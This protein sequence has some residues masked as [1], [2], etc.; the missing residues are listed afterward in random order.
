MLYSNHGDAREQKSTT[1]QVALKATRSCGATCLISTKNAGQHWQPLRTTASLGNGRKEPRAS[2][3][4]V[5]SCQM[6]RWLVPSEVHPRTLGCRRGACAAPVPAQG[7]CS[8]A[9]LTM[10]SSPAPLR[11]RKPTTD[12]RNTPA[13][14]CSSLH[15]HGM[16]MRT[17]G[18]CPASSPVE[19][20]SRT[21]CS[22]KTRAPKAASH[23]GSCRPGVTWKRACAAPHHPE[24]L[25]SVRVY[26]GVTQATHPR[27]YRERNEGSRPR[28]E[29]KGKKKGRREDETHLRL[30][31]WSSEWVGRGRSLGLQVGRL[32]QYATLVRMEQKKKEGTELRKQATKMHDKGTEGRFPLC[33]P[34]SLYNRS[35]TAFSSGWL[36]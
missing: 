34:G 33:I 2:A 8:P 24:Q 25:K 1:P 15:D 32:G 18:A 31:S 20:T 4:L 19:D 12:T 21:R 16:H 28:V 35:H 13:S 5:K 23:A 36:V 3:S 9:P 10:K 7:L 17:I 14:T 26:M 11:S 27:E 30:S 22:Y 6:R 29:R